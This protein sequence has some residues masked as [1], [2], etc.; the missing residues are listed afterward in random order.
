MKKIKIY[1]DL[2]LE[3]DINFTNFN[4]NTKNDNNSDNNS[5]DNSCKTDYLIL[6]GDI[7]NLDT[8]DKLDIFF[9]KIYRDYK[10][11]FYILGNHEYYT[12]YPENYRNKNIIE[13]YRN[14]CKKYG[15]FL[16]DNDIDYIDEYLLIGSTLWSLINKIGFDYVS[17]KTF[18][19]MDEI[20]KKH[21][22]SVEFIKS[23]LEKNLNK[24]IIVVTHYMPSKS[25][26][27]K[28]Y[29]IY[30]NSAFASNCEHLF[31]KN[32]HYWIYGHTHTKSNRMIN[33]INF[34]CNPY[35]Y[36]SERD[37]EY[38]DVVIELEPIKNPAGKMS[39]EIGNIAG[40]LESLPIELKSMILS[41]INYNCHRCNVS[42]Q[43]S[44]LLK[45]YEKYLIVKKNVKQDSWIHDGWLLKSEF[46]EKNNIWFGNYLLI[47]C[48]KCSFNTCSICMVEKIPYFLKMCKKCKENISQD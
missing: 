34:L 36:P 32:I 42:I 2:H 31:K 13:I 14:I 23:I 11:I 8:L 9:E 19:T 30:D 45:N 46:E 38:R 35:G 41:Y 6:A 29:R 15:I 44:E 16:L 48:K 26:I 17:H 33:D 25:L 4:N 22:D 7:V 24:K 37:G 39:G 43:C 20:N 27:D 40:E 47:S 28:K 21:Q 12:T 10:K 1:S 18:L 3:Y 5:D